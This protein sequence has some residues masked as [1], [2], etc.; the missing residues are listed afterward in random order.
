MK[1]L[2]K[3]STFFDVAIS[4]LAFMACIVL[5]VMWGIVCAEVVSRFFF[6]YSI[7]WMIE[8]SEFGL[9]FITF[10]GAAWL[11][12]KEGHIKVDILYV[13]LNSKNKIFLDIFTSIIG[14]LICLFLVRYGIK[15]SVDHFQRGVVT[16]TLM[17]F[18]TWPQYAVI[19][20]GCFLILIQFLR[21]LYRGIVMWKGAKDKK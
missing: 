12:K 13:R 14:I 6:N 17:R 3:I 21:R 4:T 9:I 19:T 18:P 11:L 2:K 5:V 16:I 1:L 20:I 7:P 10:M 15:V 8:I